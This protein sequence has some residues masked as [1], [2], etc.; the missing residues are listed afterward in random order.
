MGQG[1]ARR[2]SCLRA[3]LL[4]YS[5]YQDES[6]HCF[7]QVISVLR[8]IYGMALLIGLCLPSPNESLKAS[9]LAVGA[10]FVWTHPHSLASCARM[11]PVLLA[12]HMQEQEQTKI[13]FSSHLC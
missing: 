4:D 2:S 3:V 9:A 6:D 5:I 7:L 13:D 11:L 8:T 10:D 12:A 1:Q